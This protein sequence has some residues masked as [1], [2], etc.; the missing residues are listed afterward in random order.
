M[1]KLKS[2]YFKEQARALE[3]TYVAST[4]FLLT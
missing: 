2:P 4:V 1:A 3:F